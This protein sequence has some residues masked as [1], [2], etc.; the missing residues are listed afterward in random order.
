MAW[1]LV[2]SSTARDAEEAAA[3]ARILQDPDTATVASLVRRFTAIVRAACATE[4]SK[5]NVAALD[6]W[7]AEARS[8]GVRMVETFATGLEQDGDAVRAALTAPW[9]S[10]QA[11]GQI[12]KLKLLKRQMYGRANLDLLRKR[13]LLVA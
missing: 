1:A 4:G 12:N 5:G 2:K 13:T 8:C 11:E 9:S 3:V 10:G 6:A 7:L